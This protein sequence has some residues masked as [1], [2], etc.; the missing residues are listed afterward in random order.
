MQYFEAKSKLITSPLLLLTRSY[1]DLKPGISQNKG[2][3]RIRC[4]LF[5][6]CCLLL[7]TLFITTTGETTAQTTT[8]SATLVPSR[9]P[10]QITQ[11]A[12]RLSLRLNSLNDRL[13]AIEKRLS[14]RTDIAT[15]SASRAHRTR[16][17]RLLKQKSDLAAA[18]SQITPQIASVAVS[19]NLLGPQSTQSDYFA[20]RVRLIELESKIAQIISGQK[21]MLTIVRQIAPSPTSSVSATK[22]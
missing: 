15:S 16:V 6:T 1:V 5:I 7:L 19:L 9:D 10:Q 2:I 17:T 12:K 8:S 3:M 18:L 22:S 14:I 20:I 4:P 13:V 21:S 11:I